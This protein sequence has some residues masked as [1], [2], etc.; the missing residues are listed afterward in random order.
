[1]EPPND[2]TPLFSKLNLALH[3]TI[4]VLHG[5]ASFEP[6]LA[7]LKGVKVVRT[8]KGKVAF[9]I[10]FVIRQT[11]LDRVSAALTKAADGDAIIWIAY[12]KGTSE[13]YT[14]EFNRDS[15]WT[16][17]GNAGYEPVRMVAIDEDWSALRF[18]KV[19]HITTMKRDPRGAISKAG[20]KRA[21]DER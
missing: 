20:K 1:M 18:R 19:D 21:Q 11:E 12:P 2:M 3:T 10:A 15:G 13:N 5:P 16:V 7:A 17:L 14:C 8:I 4:T 6:E 9:A